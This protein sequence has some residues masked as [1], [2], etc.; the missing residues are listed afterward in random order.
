[1]YTCQWSLNTFQKPRKTQP[2]VKRPP[3]KRLVYIYCLKFG[4]CKHHIRIY[5]FTT[6]I[7]FL[8]E[9]R[10]LECLIKTHH[11]EFTYTIQT[12]GKAMRMILNGDTRNVL[13]G[14]VN[15]NTGL[16]EDEQDYVLLSL[17]HSL[18]KWFTEKSDP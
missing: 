11:T 16:S 18:M 1:M 8:N 15:L 10:K 12:L 5:L 14:G 13:N 17:R 9:K 4:L 7:I 2:M 3:P 6:C